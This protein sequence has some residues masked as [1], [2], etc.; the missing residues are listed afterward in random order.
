M[1]DEGQAS[2]PSQFDPADGGQ[3]RV[4]A[5]VVPDWDAPAPAPMPLPPPPPP[6]APAPALRDFNGQPAPPP[7]VPPTL[8]LTPVSPAR[9]PRGA[10]T[11]IL[12]TAVLVVAIAGG[13]IYLM[14][15]NAQAV[16]PLTTPLPST[17]AVVH[18]GSAQLVLESLNGGAPTRT[19]QLRGAPAA[20]LEQ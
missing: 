2:D 1:A 5:P 4:R 13:G 11:A 12:V 19:G 14:G 15:R 17:V 10:R 7:L 9:K 18:S 16:V 3:I 6:A 8:P 20:I